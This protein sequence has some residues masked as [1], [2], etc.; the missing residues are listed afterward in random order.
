MTFLTL[1]MVEW[2]GSVGDI[3]VSFVSF[4][5]VLLKTICA[6]EKNVLSDI[7]NFYLIIFFQ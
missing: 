4:E 3:L 6:F 5:S 2:D 1:I 7:F